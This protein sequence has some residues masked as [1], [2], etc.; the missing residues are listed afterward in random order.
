MPEGPRL[1]RTCSGQA[2]PRERDPL[3][4]PLSQHFAFDHS[5][6]EIIVVGDPHQ[7]H[8][9]EVAGS[10]HAD[11]VA[12]ISGSDRLDL[13]QVVAKPAIGA[14]RIEPMPLDA[15][16]DLGVKLAEFTEDAQMAPRQFPVLQC[17]IHQIAE[18][19]SHFRLA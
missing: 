11:L 3:A 6:L 18:G 17:N 4:G 7:H 9:A 5:G 10:L 16:R 1:L 8:L 13:D 19:L 2:A 14:G 15:M 12:A